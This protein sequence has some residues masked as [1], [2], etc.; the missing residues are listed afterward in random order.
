MTWLTRTTRRVPACDGTLRNKIF[1]PSSLPVWLCCVALIGLWV[2]SASGQSITY[3]HTDALGSVVAESDADGNVIK[4]YGY[5][6]YAAVVAGKITDRPGYSGHVSDAATGL[7]Y[8]QQRYMDPQLGV[9][10]SVDPV[11]A[12]EQPTN[13]FSRYR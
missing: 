9:F 2:S 12:Y 3:I 8:M 6:P 11:T 7:S 5:E 10:P 4:R 1:W 13:Q